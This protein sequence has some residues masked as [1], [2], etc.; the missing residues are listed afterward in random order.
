VA[1]CHPSAGTLVTY[2]VL[3]RTLRITCAKCGRPLAEV[4]VAETWTGES[5]TLTTETRS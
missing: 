4:A 1:G 3:S 5:L 2:R